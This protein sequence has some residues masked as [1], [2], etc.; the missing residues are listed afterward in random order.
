MP[1][2]RIVIT[3]VG[4]IS[5]IGIG[6]EQYWEGLREGRSGIKPITL[7]DTSRFKVKAGGEVTDFDPLVFL[8]K[9]GLEIWIEAQNC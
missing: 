9:K 5:P 3:G 1:K 6:K 2:K 7:F 8:E 4:V